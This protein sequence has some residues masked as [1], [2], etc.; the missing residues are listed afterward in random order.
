MSK[1]KKII[2]G[3]IAGT[4]GAL[5]I[6][7]YCAVAIYYGTHFFPGTKINGLDCGR[8]NLDTVNSMMRLQTL[9][10]TLKVVG[11]DPD[12]CESGAVLLN[13][14]AEDIDLYD[15]DM[16][17]ELEKILEGQN[18]WVW[19]HIPGSREYVYDVI[20]DVRYD[21]EMVMALLR[22]C[23]AFQKSYMEEPQDAY[24]GEYSES[25]GS[26]VIIP[27]TK[28]S[29]LNTDEGCKVIKEAI[30][31]RER[32]VDLEE[33]DCYRTAKVRADNDR[34]L[35]TLEE[36]NLW[37][38]TEVTYDWNGNAVLLD[39]KLL[40]DW[41]SISDNQVTL[42]EDAVSEFVNTNAKEYDTYG[43]KRTFVTTG[44]AEVTL[45]SGAYGW[46]TDRNAETEELI[47]LIYQGSVLEKEP[48]YSMRAAQ[49]GKND[50]GNSYVEID[51]THQHLYLYNS[52]SIVVESDFVSGNVSKG[53][54]TPSGVFGVTYKTTDAVLRGDNYETPVKY[55]MPFNGNIGMHDATWRSDFGGDIY[56]TNG[57]HGCINLPYGKAKEIYQYVS[58]G[59]PV[60]C[61][62]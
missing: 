59:F 53:N 26:Y 1:K 36:A 4:V 24:I 43:K 25:E 3:S 17:A 51:L 41:I 34:L 7:G 10:Y 16:D 28:G 15:V 11:R 37:L 8:Q 57:S 52:G 6:G 54:A 60:V 55:W 50:I 9:D 2:I 14:T 19:I 62:Y 35:D 21:E 40:K 48:V 31:N 18:N 39:R 42:D 49:K 44:G 47:E 46:R 61:Y 23:K 29:L 27:D 56:L 12:T 58:T 30:E 32:S 45:N 38:S 22:D 5:L 13:M 20:T 33:Q